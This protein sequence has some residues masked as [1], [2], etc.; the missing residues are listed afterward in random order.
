MQ[1]RFNLA[2]KG[3]ICALGNLTMHNLAYTARLFE[4]Q[5]PTLFGQ[6]ANFFYLFIFRLVFKAIA[7]HPTLL[8]V[9]AAFQKLSKQ[10]IISFVGC[11][12]GIRLKDLWGNDLPQFTEGFLNGRLL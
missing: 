9:A 4:C 10:T 1:L 11:S 12:P 2:F 3:L 7:L 6:H 5:R 8:H